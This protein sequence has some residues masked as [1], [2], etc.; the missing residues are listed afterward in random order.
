MRSTSRRS[1]FRRVAQEG[2]P[3]LVA[4]AIVQALG[5]LGSFALEFLIF[6][7]VWLLTG[8]AYDLL[9]ESLALRRRVKEVQP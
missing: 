1:L 9:R 5:E 8:V 7:P 2:P 6:V 4:V 3:V